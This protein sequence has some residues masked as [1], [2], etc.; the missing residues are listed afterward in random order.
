M[1]FKFYIV[2]FLG[3]CAFTGQLIADSFQVCFNYSC[4]KYL[5]VTLS[6]SEWLS[7]RSVFHPNATDSEGERKQISQAIALMENLVGLKTG[8]DVDKG[9]NQNTGEYGQMDCIDESTNTTTYLKI[10]EQRDW[11][12]FHSVEKPVKRNPFFFFVHWSAAIYDRSSDSIYVVDSWFRDNGQLPDVRP[13]S[14]WKRRKNDP[15][16]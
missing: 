4:E 1:R 13:L 6:N 5:P 9:R 15:S 10:F 12:K 16:S 2:T 11:L 3:L 7:L 14:N 8:T